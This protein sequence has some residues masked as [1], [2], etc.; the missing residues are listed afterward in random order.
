MI[1]WGIVISDRPYYQ[2]TSQSGAPLDDRTNYLNTNLI[3]DMPNHM[4][5]FKKFD[6]LFGRKLL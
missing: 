6:E 5:T 2:H 4:N 1:T 3:S